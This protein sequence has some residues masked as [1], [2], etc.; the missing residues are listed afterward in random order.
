VKA[1]RTVKLEY[2]VNDAP[3]SV[4]QATVTI[5]I[6]KGARVVKAIVVGGRATK[7]PLAFRC[8]AKLKKGIYGW[9]VLATDLAGNA[10]SI[11]T[12]ARLT[13]R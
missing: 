1:G 10:A 3:P 12:A 7:T 8:K 13:V 5:Q 4:G 9:R 11:M 2:V 6:R